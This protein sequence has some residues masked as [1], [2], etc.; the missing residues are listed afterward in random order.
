[1]PELPEAET[2]ARG[3]RPHVVGRTVRRVEVHHAD[4]LRE[5]PTAFRRRAAGRT[6]DGL[7]RRAKNLVFRLSPDAVM[8]V[9]L[10]M[11]GWL[12]VRGI[13]GHD[14]PPA[15]HPAV[16]FHFDDGVRMV[17]DDVRR[18]GALELFDPEGWS[19]REARFGPEP[20]G[21]RYTARRLLADLG[22][23][24]SPVRNWLLD[25]RRIAGVG[26]IYANEALYFAGVH[27][28]RPAREVR[29]DEATRM[30]RALRRILRR[31]IDAGGTTIRNYRSA[32]GER[33]RFV[34]SLEVYG[35]EGE[36]CGRCGTA[37]ERVVLA[38]RSAFLCPRCQR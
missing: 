11:T 18:F 7:G 4:V 9:N 22:A 30:H 28:A 36:P 35:R 31:A 1:M 5:A 10:G 32:E 23:S 29:A 33:G 14:P 17:Y 13:P 25:Q 3:L 6:I 19:A 34:A 15:T 24:R 16:T 20:L 37:I 12:S 27:P 38:N 2:L 21:E 8:V 26:N